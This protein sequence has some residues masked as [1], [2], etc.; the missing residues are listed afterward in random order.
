MSICERYT[1][2]GTTRIN[3]S[4]RIYVCISPQ[5]TP[6]LARC[7]VQF[8][9]ASTFMHPKTSWHSDKNMS[10]TH[11][12]TEPHRNRHTPTH[13]HMFTHCTRELQSRCHIHREPR[14]HT[15]P[16]AEFGLHALR[17]RCGNVC[18]CVFVTHTYWAHRHEPFDVVEWRWSPTGG[19]QPGAHRDARR[20]MCLSR[21]VCVCVIC[22][23]FARY[24]RI[25]INIKCEIC[26][27]Y[28]R[29][30]DK[31]LKVATIT[32]TNTL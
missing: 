29:G 5:A 21:F 27:L 3:I 6:A 9:S 31:C 23:W 1:L 25:R 14:K 13:V 16:Y 32:H 24:E 22:I 28:K 10:H 4:M 20:I 19:I 18:V 26:Y 11:T 15:W 8:T 2:N 12:N 30:A 17:L 7:D